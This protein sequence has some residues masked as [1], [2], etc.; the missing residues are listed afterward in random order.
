MTD[1][2]ASVREETATRPAKREA[3]KKLGV[4]EEDYETGEKEA[5]AKKV[6]AARKA[7][8]VQQ[9]KLEKR[10][11]KPGYCENCADKFEDFDEVCR[12]DR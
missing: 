1:I 8:A 9:R 3:Q 7:K 12:E 6:E 10:D 5:A 2:T 11:P 4:I